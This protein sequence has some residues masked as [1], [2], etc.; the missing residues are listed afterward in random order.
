MNRE[1]AEQII[2]G[3][4]SPSIRIVYFTY[5]EKALEIKPQYPFLYGLERNDKDYFMHLLQQQC[6]GEEMM[7]YIHIPF[8]DS[9]C[10]FCCFDRNLKTP[11]K[12]KNYLDALKAET[13]MYSLTPYVKSSKFGAVYFGGGTPSA[14]SIEE[15]SDIL[16]VC[17][18]KLTV[19]DDAEITIEGSTHN[20]TK[21][22]MEAVLRNGT[23]RISL[24]VQTFD[25]TIRRILN[26][27]DTGKQAIEA[28]KTAHGVGCQN[29]DID[30]IY[31]LPGQTLDS[32]REDLVKAVELEVE[33]V[34]IY[35]LIL[36]PN[37]KL[38]R[39]IEAG[40]V[41]PLGDTRHRIEMYVEA[42]RLLT[43]A[44]YRQQHLTQFV[45]PGKECRYLKGRFGA[46]S[47]LGLGNGAA[48]NIEDCVYRNVVSLDQYVKTV[49]GTY[50]LDICIKL[51]ERERIYSFVMKSLECL[52]VDC[53]K[54]RDLFGQN[55]EDVFEKTIDDLKTR[56]LIQ[57][58]GSNIYMTLSGIIWGYNVVTEFCPKDYKERL[59]SLSSW[60]QLGRCKQDGDDKGRN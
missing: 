17:L 13:E 47:T 40:E 43:S 26:L 36:R 20:F 4:L 8:C 7:A 18:D 58:G 56:G 41:P 19:A 12:V 34:S 37:T 45:L 23:N 46:S 16:S 24:G 28:V 11:T 42:I 1:N 38:A 52:S 2:K 9:I 31:N 14:L 49:R 3:N 32:W 33:S 35:D 53:E 21:N 51:S 27:L 60:E 59:K 29:V 57:G 44:G 54:F 25:D 22:K 55:I 30:L 6:S 48:G 50:P 5:P 39:D 10:S 15:L